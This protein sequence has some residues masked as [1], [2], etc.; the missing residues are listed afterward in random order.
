MADEIDPEILRRAVNEYNDALK[1]GT[2]VTKDLRDRMVDAAKGTKDYS[3]SIE[4]AS[5]KLG[6]SMV[7][8]T[9]TMYDGKQGMEAMNG[10]V[11]AITSTAQ[12]FINLLPIGRIAKAGL[13]LLSAAFGSAAKTINQQSDQLFKSYQDLSQAGAAAAGGMTDVFQNM[14]KFGYGLAELDKMTAIIK[15]NSAALASFG[16]TAASGTQAF[17]NAAEQIQRTNLGRELQYLGKMPDDINRGMAMFIKQQQQSGMTNSQINQN[18]AQRSAEYIKNLDLLSK[19]TGDDAA[20]L[21]QK[22]DDAMAEDAFNQT[23]FELRKKGENKRA[24]ELI[25]AAQ[26]LQGEA[27]KEFI[28]GVGGDV[29]AM[30]KTMMVSGKAVAM[31]NDAAFT[32]TGYI[33]AVKEGGDRF[34]EGMGGLYKLNALNDVAFSAKELSLIQ[35][36]FTDTTAKQ[37]E[38]MA[39]AQQE[40]QLK[41]LD[42]ATKAQVELRIQQ[43]KARDSLQSFTNIGVKPATQAL[44]TLA[45][46]A[47][48]VTSVLP[49]GPKSPMG[50]AGGAP[51]AAVGAVNKNLLDII[52]Q[53]ESR[54]N[55][56]ALVYGKKGANVPGSADLTNMTIAEVMEY[57]RGMIA[58]GHASTAVGKYQIIAST[59]REQAKKAGLDINT[60]K[61][62][63]RTQDLLAQQL[64][65]QAG[66]GRKDPATVMR[67]LAGTWASLP[68]DM[69]GRG[70]YDGYNANKAT[71]DPSQVMAALTGPSGGYDSKMAGVKPGE[72]LPAQQTSAQ[73]AP[74]STTAES[75]ALIAGVMQAVTKQTRVL[76]D[77]RD[78]SRM[79]AQQS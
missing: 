4:D 50:G 78:Y 11:D 69:S 55:Y 25:K 38:E 71:I 33:D 62:D 67:N 6:K 73:S 15:E 5:K 53:G 64:I 16:G 51:G 44:E 20:K 66:Y 13:T 40:A 56:N 41:G 61:F 65:N 60:T 49:G 21:Q 23:I 39:K 74:G 70:R 77:V 2:P 14:Q 54:G 30:S 36:R 57:Q 19:L 9:K 22:L 45:K 68:K 47:S 10:A 46:G 79:T 24:D 43:M 7:D 26:M 32:A 37:Q 31:I 72:S 8:L 35:S 18:L 52:G 17:A 28:R 29:S 75:E 63:E 42:P 58:R 59:L 27:Q 34:R 48:A 1:S 76:E 12:I 3:K